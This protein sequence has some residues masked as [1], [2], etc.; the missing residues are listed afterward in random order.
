MSVSWLGT[1]QLACAG[2]QSICIGITSRALQDNG[3]CD[4]FINL[5]LKLLHSEYIRIVSHT[6]DT[7]IAIIK[8]FLELLFFFKSRQMGWHRGINNI[9]T[10]NSR[11]IDFWCVF[12]FSFWLLRI[13]GAIIWA[14]QYMKVVWKK[15]VLSIR[16]QS[17]AIL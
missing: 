17:I 13:N 14:R 8:F 2:K 3:P 6:P 4:D 11:L 16:L 12:V 10:M 1:E 15:V 9:Y 7:K 5:V